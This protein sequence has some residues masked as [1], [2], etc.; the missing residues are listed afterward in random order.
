[1]PRSQPQRE[2]EQG[3]LVHIDLEDSCRIGA[4]KGLV[5]TAELY[6]WL[7]DEL[8]ARAKKHGFQFVKSIGDACLF[9]GKDARELAQFCVGLFTEERI[10]KHQGCAIKLRAA[11]WS[12]FFELE[13]ETEDRITDSFGDNTNRLFRFEK[14]AQP[15][16]FLVTAELRG[17]MVHLFPALAITE[18]E[19]QVPPFAGFE[20]DGPVH[21]YLLQ[22]PP[23]PGEG[24]APFPEAYRQARAK[25][26]AEL[27]VIPVFGGMRPAILMADNFINVTLEAE[28]AVGLRLRRDERFGVLPEGR[29]A[30]QVK[31]AELEPG[32]PSLSSVSGG[33]TEAGS[34]SVLSA[35]ELF[36]RFRKGAIFGLPGAG[37]TTILRYFAWR[38]LSAAP[39][40][41]VLFLNC[42]DLRRVNFPPADGQLGDPWAALA[43]SFLFP[44]HDHATLN[45][46]ERRD[47]QETTAAFRAAWKQGRAMV[48]LDALDEVPDP[49]LKRVLVLLARQL[50]G[51]IQ[52]AEAKPGAASSRLFLSARTAEQMEVDLRGEPVFQLNPL[53][54]MQL[55]EMSGHLYRGNEPLQER[56]REAVS[57]E[58]T[59][60]RVGGTPLMAMLLLL[61]FEA[62]QSFNLRYP[63]CDLI[64]RF[65]LHDVWEK[66]KTGEAERTWP[67]VGDLFRDVAGPEFLE[68][69]P[70]VRRRYDALSELCHA[71]LLEAESGNPERLIPEDTLVDHLAAFLATPPGGGLDHQSAA[72]E[73]RAW[74]ETFKR[75]HLL[76]PGG[77]RSFVFL[78]STIMEFLAAHHLASWR[79]QP[80]A[81]A[82]RLEAAAK[83]RAADGLETLPMLCGHS[84]EMAELVLGS[85]R[86]V[87]QTPHSASSLPFRCLAETEGLEQRVLTSL[88]TRASRLRHQELFDRTGK[89][90]EWAYERLRAL[91][92]SEDAGQIRRVLPAYANVLPLCQEVFPRLLAGWAEAPSDLKA[93]R[94]ELL[95]RLLGEPAVARLEGAAAPAAAELAAI[96]RAPSLLTLDEPGSP[97]DK[98]FAYYQG[99]VGPALAGFY[100]SPNLRHSDSVRAVAFSRDGRVA[101]SASDDKTLKLWEVA[102]GRELRTFAGHKARVVA[103]A[104]SPDGQQLVSGSLD[105]TLKLWEAASG[106]ELRTFAGHKDRVFA[107]ALSPDG[108]QLVS[109]SEDATLKLW[110]VASGRELRTFA[111]HKANVWACALSPDGQQLASGSLDHTLR[112]WEVASGREL[113]AFAG[114]K[115]A[116]NACAFSPDGQRL[117]S[118]SD[119]HTL[120]LWEVASGREL[121]TFAGHKGWVFACAL[122]PD[123]QQLVSGSGD[124]TLKLW[125]LASGQELRTFAGH[126]NPVLACALSPDGQQLVSGS[127]DTTLRLWEVASGRELRTF[128]GHKA[129]VWAC[130]LSPDGQQL[131]S[132]SEDKTLK[133]W[134]VASGRE[135]RTLTGHEDRVLACALSPDGQQLVSGSLDKTLKLW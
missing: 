67:T 95:T 82:Q 117:V 101:V 47:W 35:K 70:E 81:L 59:V 16:Q 56:F 132:G 49:E 98:N 126:K 79:A 86:E 96:K 65:V 112:L 50:L 57:R 17:A 53:S 24:A 116:V 114:H 99:V 77:P 41:P 122:S 123:G 128:A 51:E 63:T 19:H 106:R 80:D 18:V 30:A 11:A 23:W 131:V 43:G 71:S 93:A 135:L 66:L 10:E 72:K 121:R 119:D 37:K 103:C 52:E 4:E 97:E 8:A 27:Q 9:F 115:Y 33:P 100:G 104:L 42:R 78:H 13:Y 14:H 74:A 69:H 7:A 46:E 113:R 55:Y 2:I 34:P 110:E 109:G 118:A 22:P 39:E 124:T 26:Q 62:H 130:A 36:E 25:L 134:E 88:T 90:K 38:A 89:S 32:G 92:M 45:D 75:Q 68:R 44:G 31:P 64:L 87:P 6:A 107:C 48:F 28:T 54:L 125:E 1:M 108:Q 105:K 84:L 73:A 91:V 102:S 127:D 3:I 40:T 60:D 29:L 12:G 58:R 85:V 83:H 133:L 61:Y 15:G 21:C 120:K 76:L 5:N 94:R 129:R 111:G 20:R